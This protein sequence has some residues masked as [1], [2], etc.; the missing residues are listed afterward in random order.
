[1][2]LSPSVGLTHQGYIIGQNCCFHDLGNSLWFRLTCALRCCLFVG[3]GRPNYEN[4]QL[5]LLEILITNLPNFIGQKSLS[6][7]RF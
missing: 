7:N 6:Q 1:M 2:L 5:V 3:T 4:K